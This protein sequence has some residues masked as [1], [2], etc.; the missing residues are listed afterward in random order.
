MLGDG[1]STWRFSHDHDSSSVRPFIV[2][3]VT[4]IVRNMRGTG[5]SNV[6]NR[7]KVLLFPLLSLSLPLAGISLSRTN[8]NPE[9]R[10][11]EPCPICDDVLVN[12]AVY[13]RVP[14]SSRK[15]TSFLHDRRKGQRLSSSLSL[16]EYCR[17]SRSSYESEERNRGGNE[18]AI[19][20]AF[21]SWRDGWIIRLP[22]ITDRARM[23]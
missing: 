21:S 15:E 11:A 16:P 23:V 4:C 10:A 20:A 19:E 8:L 18:C 17:S 2:S 1:D 3:S 14:S 6:R 13:A 12:S 5:R 7:E 22:N 9:F